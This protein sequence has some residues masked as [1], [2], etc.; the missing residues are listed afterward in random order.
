MT[1]LRYF[2]IYEVLKKIWLI[3]ESKQKKVEKEKRGKKG[4]KREEGRKKR[5]EKKK[6]EGGVCMLSG[7]NKSD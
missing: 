6:K 4:E 3:E 5:R 1:T 7:A 2:D